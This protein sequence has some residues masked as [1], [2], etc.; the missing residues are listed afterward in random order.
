MIKFRKYFF[1]TVFRWWSVS[2]INTF[3]PK[4]H[5]VKNLFQEKFVIGQKN[6]CS[7]SERQW[8]KCSISCYCNWSFTKLDA[9]LFWDRLLG[10]STGLKKLAASWFYHCP[11]HRAK[12]ATQPKYKHLRS[13]HHK[14]SEYVAV[15]WTWRAKQ[16]TTV[17]EAD[18]FVFQ[19]NISSS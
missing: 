7:N 16:T 11:M 8:Q 14:H 9:A 19:T 6:I 17:Q 12:L 4:H 1:H 5:N 18:V 3:A 13:R 2:H 10:D 15:R